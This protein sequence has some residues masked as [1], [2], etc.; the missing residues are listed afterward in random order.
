MFQHSIA[1]RNKNRALTNDYRISW[2]RSNLSTVDPCR[3]SDFGVPRSP[4]WKIGRRWKQCEALAGLQPSSLASLQPTLVRLR[5]G[6]NKA[7]L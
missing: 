1:K 2:R 4:G 6:L 7:R 3:P 5:I